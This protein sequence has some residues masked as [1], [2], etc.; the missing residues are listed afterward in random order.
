M[1]YI[2]EDYSYTQEDIYAYAD[3]AMSAYAELRDAL[4]V[5]EHSLEDYPSV[6]NSIKV[7]IYDAEQLGSDLSDDIDEIKEIF[8]PQFEEDDF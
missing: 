2:K 1:R 5:L 6:E 8:E 4:Y 3:E 7:L